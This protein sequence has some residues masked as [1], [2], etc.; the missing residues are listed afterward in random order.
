MLQ[1]WPHYVV[2]GSTPNCLT[3][4]ATVTFIHQVTA[5]L[6]ECDSGSW[7]N[8]E[9]PHQHRHWLFHAPSDTPRGT[10]EPS[11]R[12]QFFS[13]RTEFGIQRARP[14]KDEIPERLAWCP[15]ADLAGT[16]TYSSITF[17]E[18]ALLRQTVPQSCSEATTRSAETF[19]RVSHNGTHRPPSFLAIR[20]VL[21]LGKA[22]SNLVARIIHN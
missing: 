9:L 1:D 20:P 8:T 13:I 6:R 10:S 2:H 7:V 17:K 22:C 21:T 19:C 3:N 4:I 15:Q 5:S 18:I 12:P 14:T 16:C 11:Q